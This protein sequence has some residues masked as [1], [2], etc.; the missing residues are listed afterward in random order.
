MSFP[1]DNRKMRDG[2]AEE[3]EKKE[4]FSSPAA[5]IG[6]DNEAETVKNKATPSPPSQQPVEMPSST[7]CHPAASLSS[8][9][10]TSPRPTTTA[11]AATVASSSSSSSLPGI[12]VIH[13]TVRVLLLISLVALLLA[14]GLY[15]S[16]HVA[17]RLANDYVLPLIEAQVF[18]S[19]ERRKDEL[20]YYHRVCTKDD[21]STHNANDLIVDYTSM[22][23]DDAV[24]HQKKHGVSLYPNLLS[25]STA[26]AVRNFILQQNLKNEDMI[27]VIENKQRWSFGMRVDQ[28][29]SVTQALKEVL[30][31][32]FLVQAL[33]R[34]MG[35]DPAIIEFT[36]ITSAYGAKVQRY[37]A[38]VV[39][40]GNGVKWGRTFV[41]SYSLFIP[42]QN[43]TSAMGATEIC[44]GSHMCADGCFEYCPN[45]GFQVSGQQNNWIQGWG[46]LVNQQTMHRGAAHVDPHGP[47]RV[48]FILTFAPRPHHG[49]GGNGKRVVETRMIGQ[50]GSYSLHWS[51]WGHTLRDFRDSV[52]RMTQPWRLLRTF[53]LYK[54]RSTNWGYDY[55][56]QASA[57][58]ANNELG[59]YH[60]DL[61]DYVTKKG[62]FELVPS[63]LQ[64]SIPP[65][66]DSSYEVWV[67]FY[68]GTLDNCQR[69]L[70]RVYWCT[71]AAF[72]VCLLADRV[73]SPHRR[74]SA[75]G[76]ASRV[77]WAILGHGVVLALG[78]LSLRFVVNSPWGKNIIHGRAY[79]WPQLP[80]PI[81][82]TLPGTLPT[83]NDTLVLD[84]LQSDRFAIVTNILDVSHPGN[85]A[86]WDL[87]LPRSMGYHTLPESLQSDLC[88]SLLRWNHQRGRR[89]LIKNS[90]SQ[91]AEAPPA[92]SR[93]WCHKELM[94]RSHPAIQ[95]TVRNLDF[96]LTEAK[97]GY[98]RET[99]LIRRT[100]MPQR[101]LQLQDNILRYRSTSQFKHVEATAKRFRIHNVPR[102]QTLK[103]NCSIFSHPLPAL[104]TPRALSQESEVRK[105]WLQVGDDVE[106]AYG[107]L[108]TG[109]MLFHECRTCF[110]GVLHC[111]IS[112][113]FHS[114]PS[115]MVPCDCEWRECRSHDLGCRVPRRRG[116]DRALS[117]LRASLCSVPFG[118]G[119]RLAECPR[120]V[121]SRSHRRSAFTGANL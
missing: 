34:I 73:S 20:T 4:E 66:D 65:Y 113:M 79:R 40:E 108:M 60:T 8:N 41:P 90:Q 24:Q 49:S 106:A 46:A 45:E 109:M 22:S 75:S 81:A 14:F 76:V 119:G 82:P 115:R 30:S 10:R 118:R 47:H 59:F 112:S 36:G 101:L 93:R 53:G 89:V 55:L 114:R 62:G 27:E 99:A 74:R 29:P 5:S 58:I 110:G 21:V 84:D 111:Q 33:E 38:D 86:W 87:V 31:H 97:F 57:R 1:F 71:A 92:A 88:Q 107:N 120:Y 69:F 23:I 80:H 121:R 64:A 67:P 61:E 85:A 72:V 52:T 91:W 11:A 102:R 32:S 26:T 39:P 17:Q 48:L 28:H 105:V 43:I 3:E 68:L 13:V 104:R 117:R 77:V 98:W 9:A 63:W 2:S 50:G 15:V 6:S 7:E 35:P 103:Q 12:V 44:P 95:V 18:T 56:T 78:W 42:L 51:Q 25:E 19:P 96:L 16:T 83:R 94:K 116:R 54:S 100:W 70:Q 37:H